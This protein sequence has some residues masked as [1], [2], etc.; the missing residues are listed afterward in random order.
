MSNFGDFGTAF[1][2]VVPD[3]SGFQAQLQ[4]QVNQAV[5]G[6]RIP[7]AQ[8]SR[9]T[10]QLGAQGAAATS[11]AAATKTLAVA[12][13]EAA[14]TSAKE[15]GAALALT[16]ALETQRIAE[17]RLADAIA[18]KASQQTIDALATKASIA[19]QAVQVAQ[20]RKSEAGIGSL[21]TRNQILQGSILGVSRI[22]PVAV[23]GL[24]LYGSAAIAAGLAVKSAVT[25]AADFETTLN[26]FQAT[27]GAT[28]D[29][30]RQI[31]AAA[32]ELGRDVTLPGVSAS[33]AAVG[34]TEL[35]KA[36]LSVKDTLAGARGVLQLSRA[37]NI[38]VGEAAQIAATQ[39]N[40]FNLDGSQA[41]HVAD[42]LA[43]ASISAQGEI[44]DFGAA[45]QQVASVANQVGL[46]IEDTTALLTELGKAGLRGADG[47]TSLRTTLLRLV[48]T[49]KEARQYVQALG[50]EFDDTKS[51]GEQIVPLI[52]Q[53]RH[54]LELLTPA[55]Q[56]EALAQIFGQDAI[57]AASILFSQQTGTLER[58]RAEVDR[59]GNAQ[60]LAEARSKG[61][62]GAVNNLRNQGETLGL[63]FGNLVKGPLTDLTNELGAAAQAASELFGELDALA[64]VKISIPGIGDLS[65]AGVLGQI[66]STGEVF[67]VVNAL[68]PGFGS[69]AVT[70][71]GIERFKNA[72]GSDMDE[73]IAEI[74]RQQKRVADETAKGVSSR[75]VDESTIRTGIGLRPDE[76]AQAAAKRIATG[77]LTAEERKAR[78]RIEALQKERA[79]KANQ[80]I[81]IPIPLQ[82]AQIEAQLASDLQTERKADQAIVEFLTKRLDGLKEGTKKYVVVAGQLLQ[83]QRER[84]SVV[85]QIAQAADDAANKRKKKEQDAADALRQGLSNEQARLEIAATAAN[86]R[87]E[88]ERRLI[89]FLK[90]EAADSRLTTAERLSYA[91]QLQSEQ[92]K[93]TE[94][95][96]TIAN[97]EVQRRKALLD[98]RIQQAEQL[99]PNNVGRQKDAINDEISFLR[100]QQKKV[101]RLSAEWISYESEITGLKARIKGLGGGQGFTLQQFFQEAA[102][103]FARFG[104]N[105]TDTIA[106]G[107]LSGQD[108]RG[109]LGGI[110]L[111]GVIQ[112]KSDPV[113]AAQLSEQEKQTYYLGVIAGAVSGVNAPGGTKA[114]SLVEGFVPSWAGAARRRAAYVT[115]S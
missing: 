33:D 87:G 2:R 77:Q 94:T 60:R 89:A 47:G 98:L 99:T 68:F 15:A 97:A 90:K 27:T 29:E 73:V 39:L 106:G 34:M 74:Q 75:S 12:Q 82:Q 44:S 83:A 28:E 112:T 76:D 4:A 16:R 17:Q 31:S 11:T 45:F 32:I 66:G 3:A 22:T 1:V 18:R 113:Q 21:T 51:V 79:Q 85:D 93:Q 49:T 24:G 26:T 13:G 53:Y 25:S 102:D 55:Q 91:K 5:Q 41:A 96:K 56:Q 71:Q 57:R 80:Q 59:V 81:P 48:P 63:Q 69:A 50:I 35:A 6:V 88:A 84:D 9:V 101:K 40:A 23:F 70:K 61:L 72:L 30:M 7:P 92:A 104:S 67:S 65:G 58:L 52:E 10:E 36:G 20:L 108:A 103:E 64:H 46:S 8:A 114:A 110:A 42:L 38:S 86:N 54:A 14:V 100:E 95:I 107:I 105:V 78:A 111:N 19:Q 43:G 115:G 37:A 62:T 109:T